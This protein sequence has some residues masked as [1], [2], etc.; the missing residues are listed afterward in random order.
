MG[1]GYGCMSLALE[2]LSSARKLMQN[3]CISM[4]S[5]QS[6]PSMILAK[7]SG[8]CVGSGIGPYPEIVWGGS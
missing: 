1:C 6:F 3:T 8:S 7:L 4:S 5:I 2:A